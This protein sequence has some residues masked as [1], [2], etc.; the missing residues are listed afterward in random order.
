M[1]LKLAIIKASAIL[2][3]TYAVAF[4]SGQMV[5]TIPMLAAATVFVTTLDFDSS[6]KKKE[7]DDQIASGESMTT[8]D[9]MGL[10]D[11]DIEGE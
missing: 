4:T 10:K 7:G 2:A 5:Y 8:E 1:N 3:P 9:S 6:F 11:I